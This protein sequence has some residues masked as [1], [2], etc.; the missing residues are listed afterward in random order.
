MSL[1]SLL[2]PEGAEGLPVTR[3]GG[4]VDRE[5]HQVRVL[6]EH[7]DQGPARLLQNHGNGPAAKT[8][9]QVR[10]PSLH[11]FRGILQFPLPRTAVQPAGR[12]RQ[13][14][15]WSAQSMAANAAH[16]G[17]DGAA[18]NASDM[19]AQSSFSNGLAWLLTKAL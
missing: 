10:R 19:V 18:V 1:G 8:L 5:Q 14:F 2:A 11:R 4:G 7:I 17:S 16:S 15:F 9:L 13:K 3:R 12:S 6:G